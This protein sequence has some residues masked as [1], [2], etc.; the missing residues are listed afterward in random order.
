M[1]TQL[2][3]DNAIKKFLQYLTNERHFSEHTIKAYNSDLQGLLEHLQID[4]TVKLSDVDF[5]ALRDYVAS[6]FDKN[7]SKTNST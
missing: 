6:L 2:S 1:K 3:L 7:Y 4:T 5:F